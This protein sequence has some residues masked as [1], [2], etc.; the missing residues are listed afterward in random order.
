MIDPERQILLWHL[1]TA[2]LADHKAMGERYRVCVDPIPGEGALAFDTRAAAR[3]WLASKRRNL[4][5]LVEIAAERQWH[6]ETWALA[7]AL[8]A[9][10]TSNGNYDD[11]ER[12]YRLAAAAA[13]T[14]GQPIAQIRMMLL[15][16]QT[17]T[18]ARS[19]AEAEATLET[20]RALA[21]AG[22]DDPDPALAR[23]ML[24]LAGT[25][26]EFTGRLCMKREQTAL[27]QEWFEQAL[28]NAREQ[29]RTAPEGNPR[30]VALQLWFL[31][32]CRRALEDAAGA[33][34]YFAQARELFRLA[35]DT[36]TG[37]ML[38]I[39]ET[40]FA[41]AEGEPGAVDRARDA[42]ALA[43]EE[44]LTLPVAQGWHELGLLSSGPHRTRYLQHALTLYRS[45]RDPAADEVRKLLEQP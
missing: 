26:L 36:R 12:C 21:D 1:R 10:F 8:W 27:A 41:V 7:E 2:Q 37:M 34:A 39:E 23:P 35:D 19:F 3:L 42:L 18:D 14:Q 29:D 33:K 38:R 25:G 17:L 44:S 11:A 5:R 31:A 13:Q 22:L 43:D 15:L 28:A 9:Y 40:L 20:A 4:V 30:V 16:A 45:I 24:V 6:F 32:Q